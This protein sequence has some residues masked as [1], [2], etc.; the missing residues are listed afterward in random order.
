MPFVHHG[1]I[2]LPVEKSLSL[3]RL[4][5]FWK[6]YEG[7]SPVDRT[8]TL[9]FPTRMKSIFPIPK[10]RQFGEKYDEICEKRAISLLNLA[11]ELN[12]GIYVFW[13]GGVDSTCALISLLKHC[14]ERERLTILMDQNSILE[15]PQFYGQYIRG[16]LRCKPSN[17]I[18]DVFNEPAIVINGEHNDQIFGSDIIGF[19]VSLFGTDVVL[20]KMQRELIISLF[21]HRL[22]GLRDDAC[23]LSGQLFR[24][25][26]AA[27][28]PLRSNF[29]FL[30]WVNFTLKWQ[31]VYMR[32]LLF[33]KQAIS[34]NHIKKYYHPFYNTIEFQLWSMN[35]LDKRIKNHW[36]TYK[37]PCKKVIFD[38]TEDEY[39]R[40]RKI[41]VGSLQ[42]VLRP[43]PYH[44]FID[45]DFNFHEVLDWYQPQN[46][47]V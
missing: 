44:K 9:I 42:H 29:D 12:V 30:W 41:K 13:S 39:Y 37:W 14:K 19:A 3:L 47:F 8:G 2:L 45:E 46:D 27:P 6:I 1:Y 34:V 26:E 31:T 20:G 21:Q 24:L 32:S 25:I 23:F 33:S 38:F 40:D 16:K 11:N 4:E 22:N 28:M 7:A 18:V 36:S 43:L 5:S 10:M 17:S 15:Y 35:N